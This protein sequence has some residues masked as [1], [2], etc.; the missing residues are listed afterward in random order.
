MDGRVV[1]GEEKD[2]MK[3]IDGV[4]IE[5]SGLVDDS[6]EKGLIQLLESKQIL[7]KNT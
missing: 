5:G 3:Q 4:F 7:M 6:L 2:V 1:N